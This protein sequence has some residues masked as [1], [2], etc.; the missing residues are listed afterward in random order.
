[1][2]E[3]TPRIVMDDAVCFGKPIIKG[4]RLT[5]AFIVGELAGGATIDELVE[6]YRIAREDILDALAYAARVL[7]NEIIRQV[8]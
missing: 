1:M 2:L 6:T 8:K 3:L 5:V 7:N 4:T